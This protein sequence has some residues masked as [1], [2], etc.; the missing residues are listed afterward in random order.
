MKETSTDRLRRAT[1]RHITPISNVRPTPREVR[2]LKHIERHGP[3]SSQYL[4][5]LTRGGRN[6]ILT[7][8][9][10]DSLIRDTRRRPLGT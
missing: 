10:A 2:W 6:L 7:A 8:M 4:Y 9:A 5:E 3:Q 1:F